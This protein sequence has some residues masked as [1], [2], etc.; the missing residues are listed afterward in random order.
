[1]G[2]RAINVH[3]YF[4]R[5]TVNGQYE[6]AVMQRTDDTNI[7][8]GASGGVRDDETPKQAAIR[9]ASYEA[10]APTDIPLYELTSMS[11]VPVDIFGAHAVEWGK[12]IV[13]VPN[14]FFAMSVDEIKLS[15]QHSDI[16]WHAFDEAYSIFTFESQRTGLWELNERLLR[17]NLSYA[18]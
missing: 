2:R 5:K 6:Y 8:Q 14:Y 11:Y 17:G 16:K 15:E 9:V 7:I 3:I 1:M 18:V 4:F 12:D 13:V 10:G